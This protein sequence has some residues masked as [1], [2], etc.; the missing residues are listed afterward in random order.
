MAQPSQLTSEVAQAVDF[1]FIRYAQCWEDADILVEALDPQPGQTCLS[2]A[3]AGDNTLALLSRGP[4]R[5]IALDLNPVQLACLELRVAA[6]RE[7]THLELLEL[8]GSRQS[9]RRAGLYQRCRSQL[10]ADVRRF[11]DH[12]SDAI[13]AGIGSAGKFERYFHLFRT[14][15]LPL[16]HRRSTVQ[17]LLAPRS[18]AE[19]HRFYQDRWNTWRWRSLFRLFFS[20]FVMGRLGRDP[21]LFQYVEGSVGERILSRTRY[22]LTSLDPAANP[23]L[24][25]I[26]T[27][28]HPQAL[29]YALRPEHFDAIR[30]N[31]DRLE[32]RPQSVEAF[33]VEAGPKSVDRFNF[34]DIFEYMSEE[35]Y[36]RL[37]EAIL[38]ASGSGARMAYWNMLVPRRRPDALADRIVPLLELA[39]RL[40][41][42]DKA[43]FYSAFVVEEIP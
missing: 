37:L 14:R 29:P 41:A 12:R 34:S 36:H 10:S 6:Y 22:A 19:R 39:K 42:E 23:Y 40:H 20:R 15:V 26:L 3:S 17:A 16:V 27:G 2:I 18:E 9:Q 11:W 5:V 28:E 33:L 8:V 21:R 30:A 38:A 25:W 1:H 4:A 35:A 32:W 13:E 7:L 31:L 43:F 24:Q